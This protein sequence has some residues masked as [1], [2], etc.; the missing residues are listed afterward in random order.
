MTL[1]LSTH[2]LA[3]PRVILSLLFGLNLIT[4]VGRYLLASLLP[5][6]EKTFAPLSKEE[7]G[8]FMPAFL[9]VFMLS[10][11]LFGVLGDRLPRRILLGAGM[12]TWGLAAAAGGLVQSFRQMLVTRAIV[13]LG[14]SAYS[15]I[16]PTLVTDLYPAQERGRALGV[17]YASLPLGGALAYI[18]GG[19]VGTRLGWR[20]AVAGVGLAGLVGGLLIFFIREPTRGAAE[21]LDAE[22]LSR[23][24]GRRLGVAAY[25]ALLTNPSYLLDTLAMTA[26]GFAMNGLSYWMPTFLHLER[27][28][29]LEQ[30]DLYFGLAAVSMGI[31]GTLGG[32]WLSDRLAARRPGAHAVVSGVATL[33]AFPLLYL[34]TASKQP[35]IYWTAM[36]VAVLLLFVNTGPANTVL[37]NVVEPRLRATGFALNTLIVHALGE[38]T[39][40]VLIGRVADRSDLGTAFSYTALVIVVSG[41]FWLAAAPF[42]RR[43]SL[44]A[45]AALRARDV[46]EQAG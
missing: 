23:Y 29:T 13:G 18:I 9:L 33:G 5:L 6:L 21:G 46:D 17:L 37:A 39:S 34:L 44:R 26:Y 31:L 11:P 27:G 25:A 43:D 10:S 32:G 4:Y 15:T 12:L 1:P 35:M 42:V 8:Y 41:L 28:L 3:R 14:Q 36:A 22:A 40:P 38:M 24:Q 30:A 2:P 45:E 20:V 7:L 16:T 19:E